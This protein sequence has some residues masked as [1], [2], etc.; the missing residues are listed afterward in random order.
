MKKIPIFILALLF[1]IAFCGFS[2]TATPKD[3]FAGK[4]EIS[5]SGT[6]RG[7]VKFV[8]D[9]GRKDGKLTGILVETVD[10][11]QKRP[12]TKIEESATKIAIFFESSQ[13]G[14]LSI[15]L[16]KVDDNNLK[17]SLMSYEAVAKRRKEKD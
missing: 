11:T 15:D 9:L 3:F 7:D 10:S 4:W 8:T 12:I 13:A 1:G 2:Q 17:G 5:I 16:E 6:P 14:E